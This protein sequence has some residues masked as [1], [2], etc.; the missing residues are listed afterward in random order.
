MNRTLFVPPRQPEPVWTV[1][2]IGDA[3]AA[4]TLVIGGACLVALATLF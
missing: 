4:L 3:M 2:R 1:D